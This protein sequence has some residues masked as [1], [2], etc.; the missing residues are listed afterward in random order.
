MTVTKREKQFLAKARGPGEKAYEAKLTLKFL[1][2]PKLNFEQVAQKVFAAVRG[3][4]D[5]LTMPTKR[6]NTH[7]DLSVVD[8]PC[9]ALEGLHVDS[10]TRYSVD[11]LWVNEVGGFP[12]RLSQVKLM[13]F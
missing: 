5:G 8:L 2:D 12:D 4:L 11:E 6:I 10:Y 7:M 9:E 13:E 3:D 1:A